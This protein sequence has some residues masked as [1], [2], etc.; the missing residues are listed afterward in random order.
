MMGLLGNVAEVPAL[1]HKLMT[2]EFVEEFAFLLDSC[3]DGKNHIVTSM[4]VY[5][6]IQPQV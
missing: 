2:K 3:S 5:N 4:D 6:T 1:R